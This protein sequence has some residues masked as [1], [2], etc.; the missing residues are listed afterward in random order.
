MSYSLNLAVS[1]IQALLPLKTIPLIPRAYGG[2]MT[3]AAIFYPLTFYILVTTAISL[4]NEDKSLKSLRRASIVAPSIRMY[5]Q[6]SS[7]FLLTVFIGEV[8]VHFFALETN[9]VFHA[10][11]GRGGAKRNQL[12]PPRMIWFFT[13]CCFFLISDFFFG[14]IATVRPVFRLALALLPKLKLKQ[15]WTFWVSEEVGELGAA[16]DGSL[17]RIACMGAVAFIA[18][19]GI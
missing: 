13:V 6:L 7:I 2:P 12:P 4:L 9:G 16:V 19:F 15:T 11:G 14:F 3:V 18:Y 8:I 10:G 1:R 5:R 17:H